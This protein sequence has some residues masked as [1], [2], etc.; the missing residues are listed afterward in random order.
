M[1]HE[2]L[3]ALFICGLRDLLRVT[4]VGSNVACFTVSG[5]LL[6]TVKYAHMQHFL[7]GSLQNTGLSS[8]G[9]FST[10]ATSCKDLQGFN[11]A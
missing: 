11:V 8:H 2:I 7:M 6:R 5:S 4:R 1:T 9:V 10:D 3:S